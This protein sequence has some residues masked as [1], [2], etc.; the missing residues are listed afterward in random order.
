MFQNI[1][2]FAFPVWQNISMKPENETDKNKTMEALE[3]SGLDEKIN[4]YEN[5]IDTMLLRIFDPNGVD[6]VSYTHLSFGKI[7][8]RRH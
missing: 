5:K 2:I 3:R 1:E 6:S 8:G 7:L 4:K